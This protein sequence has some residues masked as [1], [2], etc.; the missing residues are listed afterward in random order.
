MLKSLP[1]G[2]GPDRACLPVGRDGAGRQMPTHSSAF[3]IWISF[4]L[5]ALKFDIGTSDEWMESIWI[6]LGHIKREIWVTPSVEQP[7]RSSS[8]RSPCTSFPEL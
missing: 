5:W 7:F 1:T 8:R 4:E 6:E 3:V 2:P